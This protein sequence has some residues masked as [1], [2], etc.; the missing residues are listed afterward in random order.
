V[1]EAYQVKPEQRGLPT[2]VLGDKI[3]IGE[4]SNNENLAEIIKDGIAG[5]GI[6]FPEIPG[7]DPELL[8]S[9]PP[10]DASAE[11]EAARLPT[12]KHAS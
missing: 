11:L 3:L 2:V 4:A 8:V 12:R 9:V 5:S 7:V 6:A 10:A 1:E